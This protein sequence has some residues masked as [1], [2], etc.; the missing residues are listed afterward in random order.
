MLKNGQKLRKKDVTYGSFSL[1]NGCPLQIHIAIIRYSPLCKK[2]VFQA[3][4]FAS[5]W[6]KKKKNTSEGQKYFLLGK[7]L[8]ARSLNDFHCCF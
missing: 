6:Q 1:L 2:M 8:V 4:Y 5:C 3:Y 7:I